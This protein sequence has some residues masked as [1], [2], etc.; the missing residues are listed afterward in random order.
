[1]GWIVD[2]LSEVPLS[3]VLREKVSQLESK[4][5]ALEAENKVLKSENADLRLKLDDARREVERLQKQADEKRVHESDLLEVQQ[6]TLLLL[7][8]HG[9]LEVEDIARLSGQSVEAAKYHVDELFH[10][11]F[12]A[13]SS[14]DDIEPVW[15]LDHKGR[16]YL[17]QRGL[18][19]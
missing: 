15:H 11:H 14:G 3:A 18:L 9:E 5:T 7:A 10:R 8:K 19:K 1:M 6:R 13:W 4:Y 2:L 17:V 16:G 12:V